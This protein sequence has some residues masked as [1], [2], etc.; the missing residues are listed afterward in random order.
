MYPTLSQLKHEL[1]E[2]L[3]P[4][5]HINKITNKIYLGNIQ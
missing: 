1:I 2:P 4:N 5:E 3:Q